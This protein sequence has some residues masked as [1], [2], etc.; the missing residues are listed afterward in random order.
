MAGQKR[1]YELLLKTRAFPDCLFFLE[2]NTFADDIAKA[3]QGI[4]PG[5]SRFNGLFEHLGMLRDEW[6]QR[7]DETRSNG[8]DI[9]FLNE[10]AKRTRF[11]VTAG[12]KPFSVEVD[13][14]FDSGMMFEDFIESEY[15][16]IF[17]TGRGD[18]FK[19]V[20]VCRYDQCRKWF[21][22]NRP[23]QRACC[24][25]CR[26]AFHNERYVKSGKAAEY[27]KKGREKGLYM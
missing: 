19:K 15:L 6:I 12:K 20:R 14:Y 4:L 27:M 25:G 8:P 26:M 10:V 18:V 17:I 2:S 24:D 22:Y 1:G 9:S 16:K 21:V 23:K 11:Q 5:D 3:G 13:N 7:L